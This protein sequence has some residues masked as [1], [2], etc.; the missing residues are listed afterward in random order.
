[1]SRD[2][3]FCGDE[4]RRIPNPFS[5]NAAPRPAGTQKVRG[6]CRVDAEGV[7]S[8]STRRNTRFELTRPMTRTPIVVPS[9]RS[10]EVKLLTKNWGT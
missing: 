3:T 5:T 6:V 8:Q 2:S 1:V 9:I 4:L 10:A 7:A